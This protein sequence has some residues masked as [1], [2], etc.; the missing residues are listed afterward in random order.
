MG[1]GA[2]EVVLDSSAIVAIFKQEPGYELLERKIDQADAIREGAPT[3]VATAIVLAR[4]TGKDQRAAV[5][6]Y[7]APD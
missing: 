7:F 3:L 2:F 4:S 6:A 5:E 1:L